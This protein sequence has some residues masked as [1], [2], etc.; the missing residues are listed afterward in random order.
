MLIG[1]G[2]RKY[3][4]ASAVQLGSSWVTPDTDYTTIDIAQEYD[5]VADFPN[6][7]VNRMGVTMQS[8]PAPRR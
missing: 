2:G 1:N 8:R 5:P 4:G 7:I 6:D 3:T